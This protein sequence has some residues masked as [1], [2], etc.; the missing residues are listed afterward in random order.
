M[1]PQPQPTPLPATTGEV[2]GASAA[3]LP[4]CRPSVQLEYGIKGALL[5]AGKEANVGGWRDAGAG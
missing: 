5:W 4:I 3:H 1:Q 2:S